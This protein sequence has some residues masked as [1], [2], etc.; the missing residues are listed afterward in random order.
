[1]ARERARFRR[2][3]SLSPSAA[4]RARENENEGRSMRKTKHSWAKWGSSKAA[5]TRPGRKLAVQGDGRSRFVLSCSLRRNTMNESKHKKNAT[6]SRRPFGSIHF[7]APMTSPQDSRSDS[8]S[9]PPPVEN[10][11]TPHIIK[12][13]STEKGVPIVLHENRF[14]RMMFNGNF[15]YLD[16]VRYGRAV[17]IVPRFSNG[18]VLLVRLQRAPAIGMSIEF[19]RG[20][21]EKDETALAGASRELREETGYA[22]SEKNSRSL[23]H[24]AADSA[25]INS[26]M[27]VILVDIPD[28]ATQGANN[29]DAENPDEIDATIR[30]SK[31]GFENMLR[32][33]DICDGMTLAAYSLVMLDLR[34]AP[35]AT[36]ERKAESSARQ[37]GP[38]PLS[39]LILKKGLRATQ[40]VEAA[41]ATAKKA[42][43]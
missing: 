15:H 1:M 30:V 33:G 42:K 24:I 23:G 29:T 43:P 18:D 41:P 5:K 35:A 34:F 28:D 16:P 8:P 13:Y 22:L 3:A 26:K 39:E 31:A 11:A 38:K 25:T 17:V 4:E 19:P 36:E 40:S 2:C 12:N 7:S 21:L 9:A 6:H 32:N 37:E 14:F 10:S 27:E 20:G